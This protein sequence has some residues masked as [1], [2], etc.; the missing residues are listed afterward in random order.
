MFLG[1]FW[2]F[3]YITFI[4][5]L[6]LASRAPSTIVYIKNLTF[7]KIEYKGTAIFL[8]IKRHHF[9]RFREQNYRNFSTC[10]KYFRIISEQRYD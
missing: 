4:K 5:L 6:R 9:C 10:A 7:L 8:Y 1:Y 2:T 3:F